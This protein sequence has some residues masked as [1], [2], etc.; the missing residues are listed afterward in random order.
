MICLYSLLAW[1]QYH[2]CLINK[3][4]QIDGS[5]PRYSRTDWLYVRFLS[6]Q[7]ASSPPSSST[8]SSA[9]LSCRP[10]AVSS[11]DAVIPTESAAIFLEGTLVFPQLLGW[12]RHQ[13]AFYHLNLIGSAFGSSLS[14]LSIYS[15]G[16]W[17][18]S[19]KLK[20]ISSSRPSSFRSVNTF[21]RVPFSMDPLLPGLTPKSRFCLIVHRQA[22]ASPNICSLWLL[23]MPLRFRCHRLRAF[24]AHW[25]VDIWCSVCPTGEACCAANCFLETNSTGLFPPLLSK[26]QL[27]SLSC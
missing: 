3:G 20:T 24:A 9:G 8:F 19:A 26:P 5:I 1:C 7:S 4:K 16:S 21:I 17:L 12:Q 18:P 6:P 11:S 22:D 14:S 23:L 2:I 27:S 10:A 25:I 13:S 15:Y